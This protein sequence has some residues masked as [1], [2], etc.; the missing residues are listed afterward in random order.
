MNVPAA[1]ESS[2]QG[3]SRKPDFFG[4]LRNSL[5]PT[6]PSQNSIVQTICGLLFGKRPLAVAWIV[7]PVIV[8]SVHGVQ[9]AWPRCHVIDEGTY[10]F[11]PSNANAD[12]SASVSAIV[13]SLGIV[14]ALQHA[15][16]DEVKGVPGEPV[17]SNFFRF[18]ASTTNNSTAS[19]IPSVD[20]LLDF[21]LAPTKPEMS[22]VVDSFCVSDY[23]QSSEDTPGEINNRLAGTDR[24]LHGGEPQK[25]GR[26]NQVYPT[27]YESQEDKSCR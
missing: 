22:R 26:T 25:K 10:R 20:D 12:P 24:P 2:N 6:I 1:V 9:G 14:A 27:R 8:L 5:L 13:G 21:A 3:R 17:L 11:P 18:P 7:T 15:L 19:K 16:P 23:L 4:P